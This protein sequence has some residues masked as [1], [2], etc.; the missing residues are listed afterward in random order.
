MSKIEVV[1]ILDVGKTNK[2][3]FLFDKQYQIVYQQKLTFAQKIDED[4]YECEDLSAIEE[5]L[6]KTLRELIDSGKYDIRA[7]NFSTY[8]ASLV[9]IGV[10]GRPVVDMFN[11]LKPYPDGLLEK[12]FSNEKEQTQFELETCCPIQGN[13]N[14]G[15]QL[16]RICHQRKEIFSKTITTL[17]FPQY[18]SFLLTGKKYSDITSIGCHT[19]LWNFRKNNY[20]DWLTPL[21]ISKKLAPVVANDTV[22]KVKFDDAYLLVGIGIHDSSAALVPYLKSIKDPFLLVSTGTWSITLNPFNNSPLTQEELKTGSLCYMNYLGKPVKASRVFLG[23]IYEKELNRILSYFHTDKEHIHS[24]D[25]DFALFSTIKPWDLNYKSKDDFLLEKFPYSSVELSQFSDYKHAYFQL[26][27]ELVNV[28]VNSVKSAD[29]DNEIK[30]IFIDGGFGH[31]VVFMKAMAYLLKDKKVFAA[32][33]PQSTSIGAALVIH[34]HWNDLSIE[35]GMVKLEE[36]SS[37]YNSIV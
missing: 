20:H 5:F 19:S 31:N 10:D 29:P 17:H 3:L 28:Q 32:E 6:F 7:I 4:G 33:V 13:L 35:E 2:K 21:G 1:A 37:V 11:Y 34:N 12:M 16:F 15:L 22:E 36:Y 27:F 8:G 25:L 23:S 24:L 14:S 9:H 18:F 30:Q 26:I